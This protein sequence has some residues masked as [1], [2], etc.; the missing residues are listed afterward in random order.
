MQQSQK[1]FQEC[2]QSR[3]RLSLN[4]FQS[5]QHLD[6]QCL[7]L[8]VKEGSSIEAFESFEQYICF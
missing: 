4:N 7:D 6:Y 8:G 2:I 1:D 5:F 3:N